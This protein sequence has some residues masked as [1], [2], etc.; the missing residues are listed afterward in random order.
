MIG[1][2]R[3][4]LDKIEGLGTYMELEVALNNRQSVENGKQ[5]ALDLMNKLGIDLSCLVKGAYLDLLNSS[6]KRR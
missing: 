1:T 6:Q 2:T 5:I 4:H 3:L